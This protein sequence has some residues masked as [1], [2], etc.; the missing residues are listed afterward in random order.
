MIELLTV[1]ETADLLKTNRQQVRKM[2]RSG[3]MPVMK[4]GREWNIVSSYL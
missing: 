2:L 4:I 3:L 1:Q